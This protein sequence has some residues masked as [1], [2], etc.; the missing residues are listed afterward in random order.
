MIPFDCADKQFVAAASIKSLCESK[1]RTSS[2]S[3]GCWFNPFHRIF[4]HEKWS[5]HG[6]IKP[7]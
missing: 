4:I 2:N 6:A 5:L 3:S 7:P 1:A